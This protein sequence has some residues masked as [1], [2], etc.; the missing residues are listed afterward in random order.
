MS[1]PVSTNDAPT[2]PEE[3]VPE[4]CD[5]EVLPARTARVGGFDV[6]RA[7]PRRERR[8]VGAWCFVDHLGPGRIGGADQ[9]D[10]GPHPHI[11]LQTVTWLFE[12]ELLHRDSLGSEQVIRPGQLN[13]MTAGDGVSHSEET[14][15]LGIESLHAIQ[16][17]VAQPDRTR[18][19]DAGFEHHGDLPR[20]DLAHGAATVFVGEFDGH[21]SPARRDTDHVGV[22]LDLRPGRTVLALDS[23]F[24]YGLVTVDGPIAVGSARLEPGHLGYLGVDRE[25]LVLSLTEPTRALLIGGTPFPEPVLMW[26]NYVAR[27]RDEITRA[28][29]AWTNGD[30]RFGTVDSLLDR[31]DVAPPPWDDGEA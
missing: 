2:V 30:D 1:G 28:H 22:E 19:G 24:E 15:G 7:L 3:D 26:W 25:E 16:L 18:G 8:T 4:H 29:R 13:L 6:R 31:I 20:L 14:S 27:T 12:G 17:W 23:G 9:L 10:V 21:S 11:G 5:M